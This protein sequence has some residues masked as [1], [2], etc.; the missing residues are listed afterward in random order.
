MRE[1]SRHQRWF[2]IRLWIL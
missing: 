1:A 2:T